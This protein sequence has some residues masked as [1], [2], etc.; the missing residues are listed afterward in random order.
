M[1]FINF[2]TGNS[3]ICFASALAELFK[4]HPRIERGLRQLSTSSAMVE[5]QRKPLMV[6]G[7]DSD[8][9]Q[10]LLK[11][12]SNQWVTCF[13]NNP[14]QKQVV[15]NSHRNSPLF[16]WLNEFVTNMKTEDL[17][18]MHLGDYSL[19]DS[20]G[21]SKRLLYVQERLTDTVLALK[22]ETLKPYLEERLSLEDK[23]QCVK[24]AKEAVQIAYFHQ[25]Q[26]VQMTN[27]FH[28]FSGPLYSV[29][30]LEDGSLTLLA[31]WLSNPKAFENRM[32]NDF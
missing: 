5:I 8:W 15:I 17:F 6:D 10:I 32:A 19:L 13:L 2:L 3:K 14:K 29:Q 20:I 23:E 16:D 4:P 26:P 24:K 12:A 1:S 9:E 22:K 28:S 11:N 18:Q 7:W 27:L 21:L 31:N 25:K 30:Y